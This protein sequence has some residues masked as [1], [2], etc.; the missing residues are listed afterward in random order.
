MAE[1]TIDHIV[2]LI[3]LLGAILLFIGLFNQTIQTAVVYEDH[4]YLATV[5]SDLL[6]SILLNPGSP[7]NATL[8]WGTSNCTPTNFGLQ[9]PEFTQYEVSPFSLMRLYYSP[10]SPVYY[11]KTNTYY[12]N[13]TVALGESLLAPYNEI[14]NYT[15]AS[16]LLG[17]NGT[18]GLSLAL[19]PIV[20][21]NAAQTQSSNLSLTVS[22]TSNGFPLANAGLSYCLIALSGQGVYPSFTIES[23]TNVTNSQGQAFLNFS[24]VDATKEPYALMA[25]CASQ[26]GLVGTGDYEHTLNNENY[27]IPLI[28]DFGNQS[29][30]IANSQDVYVENNPSPMS[31]NTTFFLLTQG[32]TLSPMPLTNSAGKIDSGPGTPYG[33]ITIATNNP[34]ILAIGYNVTNPDKTVSTGIA[35]MPWGISSMPFPVIL[36][37]N[38]L[39]SD[40]VTADIRQVT[41][42][43]VS[44][45]AKLELWSLQG[46][47]EIS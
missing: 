27:A 25:V 13:N 8:Y 33:N 34:G 29:V 35:L 32:F 36:G 3:A 45:Q 40:W 23:G 17:I 37:G 14:V 22:V 31:Y 42:N 44:Y 41:I 6:D 20:S 26:S 19:T 12:S 9:D 11:D 46:Y 4:A 16:K 10:G 24:D 39:Q 38:P 30:L 1:A 15:T 2:A 7:S 47:T 43:G 5:C 18:F 28:A 21:V